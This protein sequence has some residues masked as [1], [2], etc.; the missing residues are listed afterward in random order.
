MQFVRK[1]APCIKQLNLRTLIS[2]LRIITAHPTNWER[3]A[4]YTV[5]Q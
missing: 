2:V 1:L 4:I 3:F 5:T